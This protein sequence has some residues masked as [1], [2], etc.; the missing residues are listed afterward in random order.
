MVLNGSISIF[1]DMNFVIEILHFILFHFIQY[2]FMMNGSINHRNQ[3][4]NLAAS[5][6]INC[7]KKNKCKLLQFIIL[8]VKSSRAKDFLFF[9][10]FRKFSAQ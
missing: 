2:I 7:K 1:F 10:K 6:N 8:A 4:I 5:K 3:K 9:A